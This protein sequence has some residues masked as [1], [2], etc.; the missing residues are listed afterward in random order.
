M[1]WMLEQS[2]GE[3]VKTQSLLRTTGEEIIESHDRQLPYKI[4]HIEEQSEI[5]LKS[6]ERM[7]ASQEKKR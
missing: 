1:Q 5:L 7:I 2:L 3:M 6:G 4:R